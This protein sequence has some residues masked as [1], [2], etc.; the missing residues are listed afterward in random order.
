[1]GGGA[2]YISELMQFYPGRMDRGQMFLKRWHQNNIEYGTFIRNLF[3]V[4]N[5]NQ[6]F[7]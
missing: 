6:G 7:H 2:P 3:I 5:A 1:M 4:L